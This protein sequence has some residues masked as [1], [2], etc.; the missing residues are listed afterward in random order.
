M[1]KTSGFSIAEIVVT[2]SIISIVSIISYP[3]MEN[4]KGIEELNSEVRYAAGSL[5]RARFESIKSNKNIVVQFHSNGYTAF[6]DDGAISGTAKDWVCQ[7]GERKFIKHENV[8]GLTIETNFPSDRVRFRN[9]VG[10]KAGTVT[11]YNDGSPFSK[12]V[13]SLTG[14]IRVEKL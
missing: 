6:V 14:R 5:M 8:K 2:L 4:W 12:I 11:F 10:V 3:T 9:R 1:D 13:L 7:Q